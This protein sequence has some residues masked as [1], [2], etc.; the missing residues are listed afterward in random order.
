[1]DIEQLR[2]AQQKEK[3]SRKLQDLED[4][5]YPKA[6]ALAKQNQSAR[7]LL[8]K[9]YE[10]RIGKIIKLASLSANGSNTSTSE[11]TK[12]EK[13]IYRNIVEQLEKSRKKI[14]EGKQ[15][16]KPKP[17]DQN[18]QSDN[19]NNEHR[20]P[21]NENKYI[22]IKANEDLPIFLGVDGKE[23]ELKKGEKEKIPQKNAEP[24]LKNH[25]ATKTKNQNK[26]TTNN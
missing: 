14:L 4:S 23:Y 25:S 2:I 16:N 11:M 21:K 18:N 24:L 7:K 1:M 13:Q 10:K 22:E 6:R 8:E 3:K 17:K 15:K 20:K 9:I 5:F 19:Q 26:K 12:E